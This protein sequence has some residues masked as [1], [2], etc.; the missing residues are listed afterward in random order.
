MAKMNTVI[1]SN[2]AEL[3]FALDKRGAD[4]VIVLKQGHYGEVSFNARESALPITII[5]ADALNPPIFQTLNIS[6]ANGV[7]IEGIQFTPKEG[8][9]TASGLILRNCEDIVVTD[10]NFV[11]GPGAMAAQQRGIS[12]IGGS[13]VVID[14][15]N[16]TG[17]MRGAVVAETVGL[18]LTNNDITGMRAEG[19]NLAGVKNVEIGF[20]KM[21]DFHP[22]PGDHP[23]FIQFWTRGTETVSENIYIHNNQLIQANPAHGVQGIFMDNDERIPYRNVT[24][25]QNII[26]SSAP[27]GVHLQMAEGAIVKD[28][29]ALAVNGS[30]GNV[31]ISVTQSTGVELSGNTTNAIGTHMST[32]VDTSSNALVMSH[33]SGQNVLTL[34]QIANIRLEA[35]FIRGTNE[36]DRLIGNN[37]D[38][39][40]L[41]GAGDDTIYGGRGNDTISGGSGNDAMGGGSGADVFMFSGL[42]GSGNQVDKIGDFRFAEGDALVFSDFLVKSMDKTGKAALQTLNVE[43]DSVEDLVDLGQLDA[44]QFSRRGRTDTLILQITEANG[45]VQELQLTGLFEQFVQAGGQLG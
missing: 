45:D 10:N 37:R 21:S 26:Q 5:A 27:H 44:V 18:Q 43:I 2:Q 35:P 29:V 32:G 39:I 1:V 42:E 13:N 40:M 30:K 24:I 33:V 22:F 6:N 41:G 19:F 20:N 23:D 36:G 7:N 4:T 8:V 38:E 14:D 31:A 15:N 11:G 3:R 34:D 28:N 25:E 9:R 17:L 12:I 16:F